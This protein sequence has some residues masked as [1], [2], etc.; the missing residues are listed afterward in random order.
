ME[1]RAHGRC[2]PLI[3]VSTTHWP[4][5]QN[6]RG[7]VAPGVLHHYNLGEYKDDFFPEPSP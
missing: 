4:K 2:V 6:P 3:T 5:K 7:T 1:Y